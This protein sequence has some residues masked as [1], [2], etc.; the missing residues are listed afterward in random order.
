MTKCYKNENVDREN[1]KLNRNT[2]NA[3]RR[4]LL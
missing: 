1:E 3:L 4:N 2:Y